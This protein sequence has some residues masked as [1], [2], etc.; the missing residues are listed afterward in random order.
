VPTV[1][2]EDRLSSGIKTKAAN[3]DDI[4]VTPTNGNLLSESGEGVH[5]DAEESVHHHRSLNF[6]SA[7]SAVLRSLGDISDFHKSRVTE[8]LRLQYEHPGQ[9]VAF[10]DEE[11]TQN[12]V[13][14]LHRVILAASSSLIRFNQLIGRLSASQ[15]AKMESLYI[16]EM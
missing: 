7:L 4:R 16:E 1:S 9:H 13:H 6:D 2:V 11:K 12:K 15:R 5:V 3:A 8:D 10:I 14:Q